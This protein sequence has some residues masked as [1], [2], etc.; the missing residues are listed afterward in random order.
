MNRQKQWNHFEAVI[1]LDNYLGFL[2]GT[3]SRSEA[4]ETLMGSLFKCIAWSQHIKGILS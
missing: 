4:I 1:L 3:F 2:N